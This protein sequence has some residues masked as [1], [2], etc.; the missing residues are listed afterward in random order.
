MKN[1]EAE[2]VA[3]EWVKSSP[4]LQKIE[5][6]KLNLFNEMFSKLKEENKKI[7]HLMYPDGFDSL[8]ESRKSWAIMQVENTLK[9]Y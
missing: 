2:R 6:F 8:D 5:E 1:T 4:A 3:K 7:F 9:K